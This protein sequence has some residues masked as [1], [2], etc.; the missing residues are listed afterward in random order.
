MSQA[1]YCPLLVTLLDKLVNANSVPH[2]SVN[3]EEIT[4]VD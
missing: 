3:C 2:L 1:R 4:K